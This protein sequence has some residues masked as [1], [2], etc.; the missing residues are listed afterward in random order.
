MFNESTTALEKYRSYFWHKKNHYE[1]EIKRLSK[2]N[3]KLKAEKG[4]SYNVHGRK[5]FYPESKENFSAIEA[6][7]LAYE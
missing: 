5:K 2:E 6:S 3:A 1:H 4:P 7:R